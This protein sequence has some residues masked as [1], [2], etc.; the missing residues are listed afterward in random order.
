MR[1]SLGFLVLILIIIIPFGVSAVFFSSA[2]NIFNFDKKNRITEEISFNSQSILLLDT[3][4]PNIIAPFGGGDIVI[5]DSTLIPFS[6]PLGTIADLESETFSPGKINFYIVREGDTI[7]QIAQAFDLKENTIF[8]ANDLSSKGSIKIGQILEIP[9]VDGVKYTIKKGDTLGSII[10]NFKVSEEGIEEISI[11]NDINPKA[12]VVGEEI[13]IPGGVKITVKSASSTTTK[14]SNKKGSSWGGGLEYSDYYTR[15]VSGG[16]RS[17]G[18]HGFN[19]VDLAVSTGTPVVASAS[20]KVNLVRDR[21]YNGGYGKYIV[22][23]H[24]NGTKTLYAHLNSTAI[25]QGVNVVQGQVVGYS[26]NTGR[27]TGPHLH[28]EVRG[29]KN[30][31]IDNSWAQ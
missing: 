5:I 1:S 20:G 10:K 8:W 23:D 24:D 29:A 2:V 7:S 18:I 16:R 4:I 31:E 11:F 19:A 30:P 25:N 22:I 26:G 6:G 9:P 12:L 17:Q 27:S 21:G 13:F 14:A 3:E 15:P 28:F